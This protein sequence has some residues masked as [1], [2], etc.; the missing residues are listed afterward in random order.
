MT[1]QEWLTASDPT[2]LMEFLR[3][4]VSDRKVRLSA[5]A[6]VR[7]VENSF[8]RV[9]LKEAVA[10]AELFADGATSAEK[11]ATVAG[12]IRTLMSHM[13][14]FPAN[15]AAY[16]TILQPALKSFYDASIYVLQ[17]HCFAARASSKGANR[18]QVNRARDTEHSR[19][20][21][22][23]RDIFGNPFRPVTFSPAWRTPLVT[24]L[25]QTIYDDRHLPSGLFNNRSMAVLADALEE[26]GCD[27]AEILN[28]CRQP[29]V[30]V[31]GCWVVDL[32][33]GKT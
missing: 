6:C 30:H 26:A 11:L 24:A 31:R 3:E 33:L 10:A 21:H 32:L 4:K 5:V 9:R 2:P 16:A 13:A 12:D 1:E 15:A 28:H 17:F 22:I 19:Q 18:R 14:P 25:A 20:T 8:T 27:N 29:G 23:V 7:P